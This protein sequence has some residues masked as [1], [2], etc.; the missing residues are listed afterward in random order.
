MIDTSIRSAVK[1]EMEGRLL[2]EILRG[3]TDLTT[4]VD[5]AAQTQAFAVKQ[6]AVGSIKAELAGIGPFL[7]RVQASIEEQSDLVGGLQV[8]L[9]LLQKQLEARQPD[10]MPDSALEDLFLQGLREDDAVSLLVDR[11]PT[12]RLARA[13]PSDAR[14]LLSSTNVLALTVQLYRSLASGPIL[15]AD[16]KNRL[17]WLSSCILS[18]PYCRSDAKSAPYL[19]RISASTMSALSERRSRLADGLDI[20]ECSRLIELVA[21]MSFV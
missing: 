13:F 4:V 5:G 21:S 1:Q 9:S 16:E 11:A 10:D 19:P 8:S 12:G 3:F 7:E 2:P 20:Q 18:F 14:P 6:A 15:S 17:Q